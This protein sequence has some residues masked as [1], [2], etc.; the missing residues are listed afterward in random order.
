MGLLSA[1]GRFCAPQHPALPS[2]CSLENPLLPSPPL[3]H[4]PPSFLAITVCGEDAPDLLPAVW[5]AHGTGS[6]AFISGSLSAVHLGCIT[7]VA[8][9]TVPGSLL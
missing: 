8:A 9:L 4:S 1:G 6:L 7:T 2:L 3:I 5:Q